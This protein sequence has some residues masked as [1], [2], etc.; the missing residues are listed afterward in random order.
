MRELTN[1]DNIFEM[2]RVNMKE[3]ATPIKLSELDKREFKEMERVI[4]ASKH[5]HLFADRFENAIVDFYKK[6]M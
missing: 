6:V 2:L 4:R 1:V 5:Y 3:V